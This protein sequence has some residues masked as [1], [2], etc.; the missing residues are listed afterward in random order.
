MKAAWYER[1]GEAQKVLQIGELDNPLPN[2]GEVLVQLKTSGINPSDV[3]TRAGARGD[4]QFPKIVP[5]SDGAGTIVDV[6][7]GVDKKRIGERVWI[8]N[9]LEEE[10]SLKKVAGKFIQ[11]SRT[12][13]ENFI[14]FSL[15][16]WHLL[17]IA[18]QQ[19]VSID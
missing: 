10:N 18:E 3:K 8:W 19:I 1:T 15:C 5:H 9:V 11:F 13:P 4:L 6:G 16:W 7:E 17:Y 2:K 14:Q 12:T